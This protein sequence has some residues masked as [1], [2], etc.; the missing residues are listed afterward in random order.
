MLLLLHSQ[1]EVH[2]AQELRAEDLN[3]NDLQILQKFRYRN[4]YGYTLSTLGGYGLARWLAMRRTTSYRP[5]VLGQLGVT[6]LVTVL[7]G[8]AHEKTLAAPMFVEMAST[9]GTQFGR[10]LCAST[11]HMGPCVHDPTCKSLLNLS[12]HGKRMMQLYEVSCGSTNRMHIC[13]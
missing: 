4:L 7:G 8:K 6:M 3:A 10:R 12:G 13:I 2:M 9:P 11:R 1:S 5:G